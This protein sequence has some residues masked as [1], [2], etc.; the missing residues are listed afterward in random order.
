MSIVGP[1]SVRMS[2]GDD[3]NPGLVFGIR[4][5]PGW[6]GSGTYSGMETVGFF[7]FYD[8]R[9]DISLEINFLPPLATIL[10]HRDPGEPPRGAQS[11][12]T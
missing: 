1:E 4:L 12:P 10:G 11:P 2:P 9:S 6:I 5:D 7:I 3:S 8:A